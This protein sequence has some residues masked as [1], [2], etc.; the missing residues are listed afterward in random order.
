MDF[1]DA[2]LVRIAER[3]R[4]STVFTLDRRDFSIYRPA[5]MGRFHLLP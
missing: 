4:I 1:A 3:E 5:R 2:G